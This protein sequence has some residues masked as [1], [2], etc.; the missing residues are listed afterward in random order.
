MIAVDRD[1][2]KPTVDYV[3]NGDAVHL[4]RQYNVAN[5][6]ID[7]VIIE[8]NCVSEFQGHCALPTDDI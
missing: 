4:S 1:C 7:P 5:C 3:E 6:E 8:Q 2:V